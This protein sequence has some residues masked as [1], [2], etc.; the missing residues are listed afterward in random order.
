MAQSAARILVVTGIILSIPFAA[1]QFAGGAWSLFDFIFAG[2][3]L[4]MSGVFFEVVVRKPGSRVS[5]VVMPV[6]GAVAG[7]SVVLGEFD[8][9][10]G[11][12]LFG[13]VLMIGAIAIGVRTAHRNA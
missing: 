8:D 5:A 9:A 3:L 11:L 12:M 4:M 1:N 13:V 10:P 7:A 6:L 2:T